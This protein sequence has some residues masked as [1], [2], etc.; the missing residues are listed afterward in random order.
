MY[1]FPGLLQDLRELGFVPPGKEDQV[2][3]AGVVNVLSNV[4]RQLS[5]G[6]GAAKLDVEGLTSQLSGLVSTYGNI[7]QIPPYFLYLLRTFSIL[8]GI[9]LDADPDYAIVQ[10][11]YPYLA[12][13]LFTDDSERTRAAL[14]RMLYTPDGTLNLRRLARLQ[15]AFQEFNTTV[16][17][18]SLSLPTPSSSSTSSIDDELVSLLLS[19]QGSYV[20]EILIEEIARITDAAFASSVRAAL[21][22][23]SP[24][25]C[26]PSFGWHQPC[27]SISS[28]AVFSP[29][30]RA[31]NSACTGARQRRGRRGSSNPINRPAT[32]VS[33][34][35]IEPGST[36]A[37]SL[38]LA[39]C[40]RA[41]PR[42]GCCHWAPLR[43]SSA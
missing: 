23:V 13:R 36:R 6:G 4:L 22:Q 40:V 26:G 11:C 16:A 21:S 41:R 42:T 24:I 17:D 38:L 31:A 7:F 3:E 29:A 18:P 43:D 39:P 14:R 20:Q 1:A 2:E 30:A 12:K 34:A 19:P 33:V 32:P 15:S 5:G 10:E 27:Q 25:P 35:R 37:Y 9:G 8:E 28:C